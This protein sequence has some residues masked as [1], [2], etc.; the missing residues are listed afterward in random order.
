MSVIY[1][2]LLIHLVKEEKSSLYALFPMTKQTSSIVSIVSACIY[3]C[4][5]LL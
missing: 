1:H 3:V 2:I 5:Y 4:T